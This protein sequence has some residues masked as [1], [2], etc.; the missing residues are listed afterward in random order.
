MEQGWKDVGSAE[1]LSKVAVQEVRV[2][3]ATLALTCRDGVFGAISG[4]CIHVG[5]PLGQGTLEGDLVVC[6]WHN[7]KFHRLSGQGALAGSRVAHHAVKVEKGRVLLKIL[8]GTWHAS[9]PP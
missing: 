6:P 4:T 1:E 7:W 8:R 3:E 5:G 9:G 2:G